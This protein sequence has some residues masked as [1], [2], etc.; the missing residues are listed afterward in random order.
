MY[1]RQA[2]KKID[3][4]KAGWRLALPKPEKQTFDAKKSYFWNLKTNK[5][6]IKIKLMPDV[7]PMHVTS[8]IYL[9]KLGF[10]D[11]LTFHRVIP[12]FMAQGGD[13]TGTGSSGPGYKYSGEFAPTAKHVKR[14]TLSM[15]HAGPGTDGSQF[16]LT[17]G[18]T[19]HLDQKHTVFG[20]MSEGEAA[21]SAL[22]KCGSQGGKTSERLTI[23]E[24]TVTIE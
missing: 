22:E 19:P 20:V 13:P 18:P 2:A 6:A 24:A 15:A 23:D 10:Y 9:T 12:G 4:A 21:L 11:G 8:T 7:A 1:K 5:G 3:K 14:G 16:F 17:F